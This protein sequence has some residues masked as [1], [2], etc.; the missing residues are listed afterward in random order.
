MQDFRVFRALGLSFQSWFRNFVPFTALAAVLYAPVFIYVATLDFESA[1]SL[2]KV[3]DRLFLWPIYLVVGLSTLLAPMLIYRIVQDLNGVKVS[4]WTSIQHGVRGFLPAIVLAVIVNV[5]QEVPGGGIASTIL[6]CIW[7]VAAPAAVAEKLG[8]FAAFGRSAELTRGRRWGIFGV[9]FLIGILAAI[10]MF[11]W[12][13]PS[14]SAAT[15]LSSV[16]TFAYVLVALFG[17]LHMFTGIVE[18]VSYALLRQDKDGVSH[19]ELAR[20]FE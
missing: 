12:I 15:E 2:D 7:F 1:S 20:I 18:A 9:T 14:V 13:V 19:D 5:L 4:L 16:R 6:T 3:I 17:V 8:P 10:L 11:A